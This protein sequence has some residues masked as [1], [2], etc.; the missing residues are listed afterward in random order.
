MYMPPAFAVNDR[1]HALRVMTDHPFALLVGPADDGTP[2][3]T[4]A[5]LVAMD[6]AAG[7][8]L[9]GHMAKANPHW[10]WL[11]A[12]REVLAI[13][14]GPSTYVSPAHYDT[15]MA[16][17][18]WNY[19]AVHVYGSISLVEERADKDRLLKGLIERH[20]PAYAAQ[21]RDL[22]ED[23]TSRMLDAIV[24]FRIQAS[25]VEAKF[26]VS[27]NRSSSERERIG[28]A[29]AKGTADEQRLAQWMRIL[30]AVA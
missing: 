26:K 25:R 28:E 7:V 14:N 17:P 12:Q 13:F 3:A 30:G 10:R 29:F 2:F 6:T 9:E 1:A 20:E 23:F 16:V 18:T 15:R 24:G 21:W 5:P 19:V 11:A 8:V 27:Q 4:H 22:P